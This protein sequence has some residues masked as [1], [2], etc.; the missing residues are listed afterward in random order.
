[1]NSLNE[2]ELLGAELLDLTGVRILVVE[3]S[4]PVGEALK[5]LL[6]ALGADVTGPAPTTADA[7]RLI[8]QQN[9]DVGIVDYSLRGG[10]LANDLIDSMNTQGIR[11]IVLSGYSPV[12]LSPGKAASVLQ[13]PVVEAQLIA[14]LRPVARAASSV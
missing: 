5:S 14:A 12:P 3:D 11:V 9:P 4:W 1:M 10:E 7:E 2:R 6:R 13:K 8:A